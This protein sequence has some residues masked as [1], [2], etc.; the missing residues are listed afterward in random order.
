MFC[1]TY[2]DMAS[3]SYHNTKDVTDIFLFFLINSENNKYNIICRWII[4]LSLKDKYFHYQ[5]VDLVLI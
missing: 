4:D 1:N 3:F 2:D 5:N